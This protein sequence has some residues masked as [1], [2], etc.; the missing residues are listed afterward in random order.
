M[1]AGFSLFAEMRPDGRGS[2]A[3][4]PRTSRP[5]DAAGSR[6]DN[7]LRLPAKQCPIPHRSA[8]KESIE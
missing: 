8:R 1:S 2:S 3:I 4:S 5:D 6:R 7:L